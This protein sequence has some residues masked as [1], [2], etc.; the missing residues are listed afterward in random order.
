MTA[1]LMGW[2]EEPLDALG[3]DA[4][5]AAGAALLMRA[6]ALVDA[7]KEEWTARGLWPVQQGHRDLLKT[8]P[9][10]LVSAAADL[11]RDLVPRHRC[12]KEQIERAAEMCDDL[13]YL[14]SAFVLARRWL[15]GEYQRVRTADPPSPRGEVVKAKFA[16]KRARPFALVVEGSYMP[17]HVPLTTTTLQVRPV[18]LT[19]THRPV[20]LTRTHRSAV[21]GDAGQQGSSRG[22]SGPCR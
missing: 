21:V 12:E 17:M 10:L 18:R 11:L 15:A 4:P 8:D 7:K 2:R 22:S 5:I 19:R 14:K 9:L 1:A 6:R 3:D 16:M 20:R 13:L